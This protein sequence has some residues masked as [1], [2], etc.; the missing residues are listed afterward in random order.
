MT[1]NQVCSCAVRKVVRNC[2]SSKAGCKWMIVDV[3]SWSPS[4]A[5][6]SRAVCQSDKK[7]SCRRGTKIE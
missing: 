7:E 5:A 4:N 3:Q 2:M 1:R 6:A